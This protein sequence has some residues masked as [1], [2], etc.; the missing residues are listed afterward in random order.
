MK[1]APIPVSRPR[2]RTAAVLA[3]ALLFVCGAAAADTLLPMQL[4]ALDSRI[5]LLEL[6]EAPAA[7]LGIFVGSRHE[8][9]RLRRIAL[10][11]DDRDPVVYEYGEAEWEAIAAG[12]LH[13]ALLMPLEPGPHRLRLELFARTLDAGPTDPRAVERLDQAIVL[14]PGQTLV[15][16]TM[17]QQGFG[18]RALDVRTATADAGATLWQ[19]AARFWLDADRPYASARLL[20]RLQ[21]RGIA[22][23]GSGELLA[24]SLARLSGRAAGAPSAAAALASFNAAVDAAP[25]TEDLAALEAIGAQ[26]ARTA[27]DWMLRDRANLL[28]GYAGLRTGHGKA[29]LQAFA[30]VRS[31]G[32]LG[33]AALLGFGWAFL[34]P[35]AP[36]EAGTLAP[37]PALDG[38]PAFIAAIAARVVNERTP[39]KSRRKALERALVP[40]TELIGR[41]PLDLDAQE[42]ALALAWA[43]DQLGTG[44]Q[45]HSYYERAARQLEIARSQLV[46]AMEHVAGGLAA[47]A[48]AAGQNDEHSGWRVWLADLPYA[49][50]TGYLK[51]LLADDGFVASLDAYRRA[52]LLRDELA[53]CEKR[54]EAVPA[55]AQLRDAV[56]AALARAQTSEHA[57]R[58]A[59]ERGALDLLGARK[60]QTERYLVEARF[61]LARHYDSA[62]APT[63]VAEGDRS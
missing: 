17:A 58:R 18:R 53:R 42:G 37:S 19:R 59:F 16:V 24:E 57:A 14:G 46:Q 41:D 62:R 30:R 38:R 49:A 55:S 3:C 28:L 35:E 11:V 6:Q 52:R 22:A 27:A 21:A 2:A 56:Q 54:I 7:E 32:P 50:E 4:L 8:A 29:A 9:L 60:R 26:K 10:R 1:P 45:A 15:E 12:G 13:P 36:V 23:Q 51:Y 39:G 44:A 43:L 40:W 20:S 34:V 31:P 61:A 25:G 63:P 48:V 5:S 47:H 33:N